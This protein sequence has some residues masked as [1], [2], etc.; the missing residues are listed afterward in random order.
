MGT[1]NL[2]LFA[3]CLLAANPQAQTPQDTERSFEPLFDGKT[4]NGWRGLNRPDAPKGWSAKDGAL[5][6]TPGIEGGDLLTADE[7]SDFELRLDWKIA[8]GGNSG[9]M[10]RVNEHAD[11]APVNGPEYQLLDD[12]NAPDGRNPLT[13]AGS[14]YAL[15]KPSQKVVKPANE[16]NT[17]RIVCKGNHVEHWLNGVKI[18]EY[19]LGSADWNQRV[20]NSKFADWQGFATYRKGHIV[21]QDHGF[22]VAFR[23]I[24]IAVPNPTQPQSGAAA[25]SR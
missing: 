11:M 20:K 4:L 8:P 16:W 18:V 25:Q 19:E 23:N 14:C 21:F 5:T 3:M 12:A 13:T 6:Y 15:Y 9:I 17:A 1:M 10:Y 24:R 7:Y 2:L 22:V